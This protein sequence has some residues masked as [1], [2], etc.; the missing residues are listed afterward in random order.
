MIESLIQSNIKGGQ[1]KE[2]EGKMGK[3]KSY[4]AEEKIGKQ[5]DMSA[6]FTCTMKTRH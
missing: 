5:P 4:L 3:E 6:F 2:D 1:T